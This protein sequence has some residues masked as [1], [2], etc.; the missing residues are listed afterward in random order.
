MTRTTEALLTVY[1]QSLELVKLIEG[2]AT[3]FHESYR[4]NDLGAA[5]TAMK[6][7]IETARTRA[8]QIHLEAIA[9][10]CDTAPANRDRI[11]P[12]TGEVDRRH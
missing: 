12:L 4:G 11:N 3:A 2:L 10:V 5:D 1:G 9:T 7:A 8:Y 6:T